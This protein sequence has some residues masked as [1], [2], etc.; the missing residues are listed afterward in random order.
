LDDV[1]VGAVADPVALAAVPLARPRGLNRTAVDPIAQRDVPEAALGQHAHLLRIA[2]G[3]AELEVEQR[4]LAVLR[5][6]VV[7]VE[8]E[9]LDLDADRRFRI[10][11]IC[12]R[13]GQP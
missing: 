9:R 3:L 2:V 12:R 11:G 4:G 8:I 7:G 13:P 5:I 1:I 6:D 10:V